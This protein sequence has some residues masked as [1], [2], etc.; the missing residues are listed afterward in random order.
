MPERNRQTDEQN[1][2]I[3]ISHI[4]MLMRDKNHFSFIYFIYIFT[5]FILVFVFNIYSF[6]FMSILYYFQL[7]FSSRMSINSTN[8]LAIEPSP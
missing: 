2:Y 1:C 8:K 7:S 5:Q 4:S 6:S 3:S